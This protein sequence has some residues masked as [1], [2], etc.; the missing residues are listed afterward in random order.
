MANITN[1][2]N[3][4][5]KFGRTDS[6]E[7]ALAQN[8][9]DGSISLTTN[10][11]ALG[12]A[13]K[14][15]AWLLTGNV[16]QNDTQKLGTTTNNNFQ[17]I[18][19]NLVRGTVFKSGNI[20]LGSSAYNGTDRSAV[21]DVGYGHIRVDNG[22]SMN[23]N[24][25]LIRMYGNGTTLHGE[26]MSGY[27]ANYNT[28]LYLTGQSNTSNSTNQNP[29]ILKM[30]ANKFMYFGYGAAT[31]HCHLVHTPSQTFV[32]TDKQNAGVTNS[33][34][35]AIYSFQL[36]TAK[37]TEVAPIMDR[38]TKLAIATPYKG[39]FVFQNDGTQIGLHYYDGTA[40]QFLPPTP[41]I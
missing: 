11:G 7:P 5:D 33:P 4:V 19:N 41:S 32:W 6:I 27:W 34:T 37:G 29:Y 36:A 25:P 20:A 9:V 16:V 38:A 31:G 23:T 30:D 13:G 8:S 39:L 35:N 15:Y 26:F 17:I 28:R 22:S 14:V 21:L 12:N 2:D 40:W 18:S 3:I 24:V 10:G 1:N